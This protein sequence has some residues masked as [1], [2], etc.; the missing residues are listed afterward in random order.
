MNE[1]RQSLKKVLGVKDI[2]ALAFGTIVGGGW[3]LL[4]DSW[5]AQA[6]A[7]GVTLAFLIAAGVCVFIGLTYA[8]LTPAMPQAGGEFIYAYRA[9]GYRAAY[10]TAW[11]LTLTYIGICSWVGMGFAKAFNNLVSVPTMGTLWEIE[12]TPV[13]LSWVLISLAGNVLIFFLNYRGMEGSSFFQNIATLLLVVIGMTLVFGGFATGTPANIDPPI[14]DRNALFLVILATPAMYA[15]FNVIPQ[16]AE[17][18][19]VPRRRLGTLIIAV[20]VIVGVWYST[21]MLANGFLAT[22]ERYGE[23]WGTGIGVIE[24]L[25]ESSGSRLLANTLLVGVLFGLLTTWNG[26]VIGASRLLYSMSRAKM[27]PPAF[28]RLH[29]KYKTPT[30]ALLFTCSVGCVTPLL[31]ANILN[32]L[33]NAE[34]FALVVAYIAVTTS[35]LILRKKEREMPRPFTVKGGPVIGTIALLLA[36]AFLVLYFPVLPGGGLVWQE[37]AMVAVWSLVGVVMYFYNRSH[38]ADVTDAER[39]YL[40]FGDEFS[41]PHYLDEYHAEVAA[42][43]HG[44]VALT[45]APATPAVPTDTPREKD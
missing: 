19:S 16:A 17:E 42:G 21:I 20:I 34:S 28:S 26:F 39:E 43:K 23:G 3:V 35:F 14:T 24:A 30:V 6:G 12:G 25:T 40:I 31:G 44:D 32:W 41:R 37:W 33:I 10:I 5:I 7:I 13:Y 38:H 11:A 2:I 15:G 18:A 22:P 1:E 9:L 4:A 8:E 27:L 29:P 36:I 45:P